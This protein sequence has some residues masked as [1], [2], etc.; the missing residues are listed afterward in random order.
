MQKTT[1]RARS[2]NLA[3][4]PRGIN[5]LKAVDEDFANAVLKGMIPM[6]GRMVHSKDGQ[7][8]SQAYGLN[9]EVRRMAMH[10]LH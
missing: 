2:I 3:L 8:N 10:E 7:K 4:S 1:E 6:R 5:A 9:G